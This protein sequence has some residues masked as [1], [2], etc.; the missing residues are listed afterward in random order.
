V[1]PF[2]VK[3][4]VSKGKQRQRKGSKW[5]AVYSINGDY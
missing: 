5:N 4:S 1:K 3:Q 2:V